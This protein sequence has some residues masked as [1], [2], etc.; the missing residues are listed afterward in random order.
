MSELQFWRFV[1]RHPLAISVWAM[2]LTI[3]VAMTFGGNP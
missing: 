1:H 3:A 2:I